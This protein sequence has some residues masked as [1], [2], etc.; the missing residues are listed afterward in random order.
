MSYRVVFS[1]SC[2]EGSF[3]FFLGIMRKSLY[4]ESTQSA[5]R[6]TNKKNFEEAKRE[7]NTH[8]LPI[9]VI[10]LV[11][12]RIELTQN[13]VPKPYH[14]KYCLDFGG[15]QALKASHPYPKTGRHRAWTA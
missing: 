7:P 6:L 15:L 4:D 14:P 1:L 13:S 12:S 3:F 9:T 8:N 10:S 11:Q 5:V 2:M